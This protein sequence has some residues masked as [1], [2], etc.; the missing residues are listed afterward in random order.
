M[1]PHVRSMAHE[2][3]EAWQVDDTAICRG[4]V[5]YTTTDEHA[6][7]VPFVDVFKLRDGRIAQYLIYVD[8]SPVFSRTRAP[9]SCENPADG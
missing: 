3:L 4:N 8:A 9:W 6:V 2:V 7:V 1:S 5:R